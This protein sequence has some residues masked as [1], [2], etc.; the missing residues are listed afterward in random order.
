MMLLQCMTQPPIR[1]YKKERL[2]SSLGCV[3]SERLGKAISYL[4]FDA[5]SELVV[6]LPRL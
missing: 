1:S 3:T 6:I 2:D 4:G 5:H